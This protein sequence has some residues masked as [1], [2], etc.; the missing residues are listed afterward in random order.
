MA[1]EAIIDSHHHIW[2]MTDL[3]WLR[4][5]MT[6]RIY[7]PYEAIR[8]DY[9]LAEF[10]QESAP[11]GVAGSVYIQCGWPPE[12]AAGES[13]WVQ[14]LADQSEKPL[15]IIGWA[16]L[17]D[18]EIDRLLDAHGESRNFRG[19]RQMLNWH[20]NTQYRAA[21]IDEATM[22]NKAWLRGFA[23]T[24]ERGLIFELM[25]F[26]GQ[27]TQAAK[28]ARDYPHATIVLEHG[29]LPAD[30]SA[31]GWA[32]WRTGM[33]LMAAENNVVAKI[34]GLGMFNHRCTAPSVAPVLREMV[35]MFGAER[36][37]FGS[38]F[39]VDKLW[40]SYADMIAAYRE[41][42]TDLSET[43]RRAIFHDTAARIYRL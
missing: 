40:V 25:I 4:A 33:A 23:A 7:G 28:L 35:A 30:E 41:A 19:I 31:A 12:N 17:A 36:C 16:N 10:H 42:A 32:A 18:P 22:T 3:P 2:R 39:P 1:A 21:G 26:P 24:A 9:L 6:P 34:S 27:M 20:A 38:N 5:P 37:M 15:A 29:G 8:R 11:L 14:S 43:E 13:R